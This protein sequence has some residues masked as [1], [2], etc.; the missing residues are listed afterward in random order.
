[1][2]GI[3]P[4][5]KADEPF[6]WEMLY[7]ALHVEAGSEPPP[8]DIVN[9]PDLAKYVA[10]WGKSTDSGFVVIDD[11]FAQPVGAVWLRLFAGESKGY[12]YVADDVPELS[13]ALLP[14][15]RGQGLGTRLMSHMLDAAKGKYAS[16]SLS[17]SPTNAARRLYER[18]GFKPVGTSG[19]SITMQVW[20]DK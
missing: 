20:L 18:F 19:T 3:R 16:I 10:N 7:Q 17:V 5:V 13:M 8:R 6:L 1:M 12:G 4:L 11:Q 2:F 15:Y 9:Q 14:D